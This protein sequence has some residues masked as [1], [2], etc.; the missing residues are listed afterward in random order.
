M[1]YRKIISFITYLTFIILTVFFFVS[2]KEGFRKISG[3]PLYYIVIMFILAFLT[4]YING[5]KINLLTKFYNIKLNLK[6]YFGLSVITT[7]GN[8]IIPAR[9][10]AYL[11]AVYLKKKH[12]LSYLKFISTFGA[13]LV[14]SFFT[15][16]LIGLISIMIFTK[17]FN[18][19]DSLLKS[20]FSIIFI[21]NAILL[22]ISIKLKE[23]KNKFLN[24]IVRTINEWERIRNKKRLVVNLIMLDIILVMLMAGRMLITF[25]ILNSGISFFQGIIMGS[26]ILIL[27]L[28]NIT[29]GNIGIKEAVI[30]FSTKI[31]NT[32]ENTLILV[33]LL[34]RITTIIPVFILGVIFT[35]I[36]IKKTKI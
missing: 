24:Y 6:E 20:L 22:F 12:N 21:I 16:S 35:Y 28:I 4:L 32:Q 5:I 17:N 18:P 33:A 2:N 10:G 8:Y 19:F 13:I 27:T 3:I 9:G 30:I 36:L 26:L 15:I 1:Q 14:I 7:M 34:D 25:H 31:T 11:R 29:P 23:L